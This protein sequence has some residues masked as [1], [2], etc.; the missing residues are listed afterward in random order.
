M[1]GYEKLHSGKL[2]DPQ[3]P[4][5]MKEQFACLE[6]AHQFN[7]THPMEYEKRDELMK[8]ML[9]DVGEGC[10]ITPPFYANWGGKHLHLGNNVYANM[11]LTVVDDTHIY[12]GDYTEFGPNVIIA[13]AGHPIL[14]SLR[15]K[16]PLQYNKPVRIGKNC[17]IG[18]GVVIV[19]GITI[20]DNSV[21]GAGSVVVKDIPDNVVAAGNPC[22]IL[23]KIG[24][25]DEEFFYKS[26]RI[27]D[28][29]NK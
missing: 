7:E 3:D 20:G 21:I 27:D 29:E 4:E 16:T 6:L 22:R 12:V 19:P 28:C 23:R 14:P 13:T 11:G 25:R 15:G 1:T 24:E 5:I 9:G 26:E 10:Y 17:W 2:Y 18:A 8:Q